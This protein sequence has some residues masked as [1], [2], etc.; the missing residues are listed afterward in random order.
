MNVAGARAFGLADEVFEKPRR[1]S[2]GS[3]G[4]VH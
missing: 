4:R 2:G 3:R 1:I